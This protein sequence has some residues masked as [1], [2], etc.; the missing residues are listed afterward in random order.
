MQ[1]PQEKGIQ[2]NKD[3]LRGFWDNTKSNN[4]HVIGVPQG[5]GKEQESENLFE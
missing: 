5:E 2:K 4:I 1:K 3:N